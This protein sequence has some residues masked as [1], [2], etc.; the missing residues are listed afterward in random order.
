[1]ASKESFLTRQEII[2]IFKTMNSKT[3]DSPPDDQS[4]QTKLLMKRQENQ[5]VWIKNEEYN[6]T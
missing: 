5:L 1:M 3:K 6:E 4:S 2:D